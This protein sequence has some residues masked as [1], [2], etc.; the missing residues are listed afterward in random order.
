MM[1]EAG[2]GLLSMNQPTLNSDGMK[3]HDD[4]EAAPEDEDPFDALMDQKR[5]YEAQAKITEEKINNMIT[6]QAE[7]V[8]KPTS[9]FE[10]LD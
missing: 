4:H 5:V 3:D 7:A 9:N 2:S 10:E 8:S 1:M 6:S